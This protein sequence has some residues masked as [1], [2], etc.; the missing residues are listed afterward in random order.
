M[1][2]IF[3]EG[4][5]LA[6]GMTLDNQMNFVMDHH[7]VDNKGDLVSGSG[8]DKCT[9]HF[10]HKNVLYTHCGKIIKCWIVNKQNQPICI[11]EASTD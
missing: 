8:N 4:D 11:M 5:T 9:E 1:R 2:K 7:T 10:K 6:F 3:L